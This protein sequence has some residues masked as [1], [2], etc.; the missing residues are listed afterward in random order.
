LH[1]CDQLINERFQ[2]TV[3]ETRDL[4][5]E[6]SPANTHSIQLRLMCAVRAFQHT[7]PTD[8]KKSW[9]A[10]DLW[11][12]KFEF[13]NKW[14]NRT[15]KME[16]KANLVVEK[17]SY[18][19][20]ASRIPAVIKRS[21]DGST[22]SEVIDV[23]TACKSRH[24]YGPS[25]ALQRIAMILSEHE[26][27]NDVLMACTRRPKTSCKD[28]APKRKNVTLPSGEPGQ[29][30]TR[31]DVMDARRKK[32]AEKRRIAAEKKKLKQAVRGKKSSKNAQVTKPVGASAGNVSTPE[33]P[34]TSP[35]DDPAPLQ[36]AELL[37]SLID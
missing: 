25:C 37:L 3:R 8:V 12:M 14:L 10:T 11:P 19:P 27:V 13:A 7:T 24:V 6:S 29:Y 4:F 22:L 21:A 15:D 2:M 30:L 23:I 18:A 26:T 33:V 32:K 5:F 1:P 35:G 31:K 34:K 9:T 16:E 20:V 17:L 36:D 28:H